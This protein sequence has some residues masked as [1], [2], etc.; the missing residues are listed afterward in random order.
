VSHS[1]K[2]VDYKG[3]APSPRSHHAACSID[4]LMIVH[5]GEGI[6]PS[7]SS[8]H[9]FRKPDESFSSDGFRYPTDRL[10][11][12]MKGVCPGDNI[13]GS[14]LK[15]DNMR[16]KQPSA[17]ATMASIQLNN[18]STA[19]GSKMFLPSE[20][21]PTLNASQISTHNNNNYNTNT[22]TS[23]KESLPLITC[24]DDLYALDTF[25]QIWYPISCALSPLP[26]KGHSL[27]T[28]YL[29][30][31]GD[32]HSSMGEKELYLI[33]FG[34]YSIENITLS[35][36]V[37][38]CEA[39][40]ILNYYEQSKRIYH[41]QQQQLEQEQNNI[42]RKPHP[43]A[44]VPFP[45]HLKESDIPPI[46]WRSLTCRGNPPS[47][48]YRHSS[49]IVSGNSGETLLVIFGGIG[50]DPKYAL[51]D[52][53]ILDI[54]NQT[55]ITLANGNDC[56]MS[57]VGGDGPIAGL[58]GHVSF[59]VMKLPTVHSPS[60]YQQHGHENEETFIT[61]PKYDIMVFG[62]S[63]N[64]ASLK[65]DCSPYLYA[66]D[67][68]SH[69]WRR[70][71]TGHFF[72]ALRCNH[73]LAVI[74]GWAPY[75]AMIQNQVEE[76]EEGNPVGNKNRQT[77]SSLDQSAAIIFGGVGPVKSYSDTWTLNL[78]WKSAGTEQ[79]DNSIEQLIQENIQQ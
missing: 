15:Q 76:D 6:K 77:F 39:Q 9:S 24:F 43:H 72:P 56:L 20:T 61:Y 25:S 47:P 11:G 40:S 37:F 41:D 64:T 48:R 29:S 22:N 10:T 73:S 70:V 16:V 17:A 67:L 18:L 74:E 21:D 50:K 52:I 46:V 14:K 49:C 1:W 32:H 12:Q 7:S 45:D 65:S 60:H 66:F 57:G 5:G 55:W 26:R 42:K 27:N 58:Y 62:G 63:S 69:Q 35:N 30:P 36:S 68:S 8:H 75:N 34:G 78:Q 51:N 53:F 33:M 38:V 13:V 19:Q 28:G 59:P 54:Q 44:T 79:Y 71:N 31:L 23:N 2:I 3:H 4:N